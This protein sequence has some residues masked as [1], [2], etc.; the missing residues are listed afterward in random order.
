[1]M[2]TISLKMGL[3]KVFL[4]YFLHFL[5][6]LR[7]AVV[8]KSNVEA[9][10]LEYYVDDDELIITDWSERT[11]READDYDDIFGL[12]ALDEEEEKAET[13]D[14]IS[15]IVSGSSGVVGGGTGELSNRASNE[16]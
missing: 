11:R 10:E 6:F 15:V 3:D 9:D 8:S 4:N 13:E 12:L 1:M 16:S 7:R 14:V 2:R 5:L